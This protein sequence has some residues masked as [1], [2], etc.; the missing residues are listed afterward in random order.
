ME[1]ITHGIPRG[2]NHYL[3]FGASNYNKPQSHS[4]STLIIEGIGSV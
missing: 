3:G 1:E 4:P 2:E